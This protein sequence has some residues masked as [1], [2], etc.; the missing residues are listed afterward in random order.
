MELIAR[1]FECFPGESFAC[2]KLGTLIAQ[3]G[4]VRFPVS[5]GERNSNQLTYDFDPC[6]QSR[7]LACGS[8]AARLD[9]P[10]RIKQKYDFAFTFSGSRVVV[11][12]EKANWEKILRDLL[13]FHLY[14]QHGADL[15]LLFLPKSYPHSNGESENFKAGKELYA[16]CLA[17]GFG[18]PSKF[19]R[20]LLVGYEQF[21]AD[22]RHFTTATRNRLKA[23][24][25]NAILHAAR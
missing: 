18:Q 11:E 12:V 25:Q 14:F 20:I 13:K 9:L 23:D 6:L 5:V 10:V 22:G 4:E 3:I 21:T 1:N 17:S 15:A 19:E 16:Q 7:L 2:Q 8:I 24:R